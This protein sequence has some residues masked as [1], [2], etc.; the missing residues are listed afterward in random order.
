MKTEW[1]QERMAQQPDEFTKVQDDLWIQRRNIK[2][3]E[4][5]DEQGNIASSITPGEG[6]TDEL[7]EEILDKAEAF[8]YIRGEV[9]N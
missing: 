9:N 8:D 1:L 3:I 5:L 6:S 4:E 7:S 2:E